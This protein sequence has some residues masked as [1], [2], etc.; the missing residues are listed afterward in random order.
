M[1]IKQFF[2][3]ALT[4]PFNRHK[5]PPDSSEVK[6]LQILQELRLQHRKNL[7]IYYLNINSLRN[8][9]SDLRVLLD[10]LQLD[11]FV[12]SKIKLDDNFPSPQFAVEIYKISARRD[13][14]GHR[15]GL[16]EFVKRVLI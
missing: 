4:P 1:C 11:Y 13:R 7:F 15:R 14:D 5:A 3:H 2:K 6:D 12:I 9:I 10:D 8:R 16:I